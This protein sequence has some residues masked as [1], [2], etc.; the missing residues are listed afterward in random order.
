[1]NKGKCIVLNHV[2]VKGV[3]FRTGGKEPGPGTIKWAVKAT[4]EDRA[5]VRVVGEIGSQPSFCVKRWIKV[6]HRINHKPINSR[7]WEKLYVLL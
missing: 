6:W 2:E 4:E 5:G 1:M 7:S 3:C